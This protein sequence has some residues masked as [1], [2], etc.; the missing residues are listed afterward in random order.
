MFLTWKK[1]VLM[2]CD[3]AGHQGYRKDPVKYKD[4]ELYF[5]GHNITT[6][7]FSSLEKEFGIFTKAEKIVLAGNT[8]GGIAVFHWANYLAEQV[9]TGKV[10]AISSNG[11]F[12]DS[13]NMKT[14]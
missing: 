4:A 3:G 8:A 11:I 2:S 12:Y 6:Q 10:W 14:R 5:R 9:K 13:Q 7:R 1:I